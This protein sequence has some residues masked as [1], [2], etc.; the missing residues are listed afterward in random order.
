MYKIDSERITT[1]YIFYESYSNIKKMIEKLPCYV[2][3]YNLVNDYKPHYLEIEIPNNK[4]K[5]LKLFSEKYINKSSSIATPTKQVVYKL[6]TS[7]YAQ[8]EM[9]IICNNNAISYCID[10]NLLILNIPIDNDI[11]W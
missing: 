11:S 1:T 2:F 10:N 8:N 3:L 5:E 6:S 9:T 4:S 7:T